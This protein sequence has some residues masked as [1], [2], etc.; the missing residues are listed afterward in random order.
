MACSL[1]RRSLP[2]IGRRGEFVIT[3]PPRRSWPRRL[4]NR[5]EVDRAVFYALVLRVWQLAGG[6]ISGV[7]I[8]KFFTIETQGYYYLFATLMALQSFFE[9]GFNVVV[10]NVSSHE[11]THLRLNEQGAIEGDARALSRLV[12]LGRLIFRWYAVACLLFIVAVGLGGGAFVAL[13]PKDAN[14]LPEAA[15]AVV[16]WQSPWA[17]LVVLTGLLLWSLPFNALLEGC[18]QIATVNRFRVIQAVSANLAVWTC[19]VSGGE[20]W[21]VVAAA[22]ARLLCDLALLLIRYRRFFVP[23]LKPPAGEQMHWRTDVWPMQW[24]LA[25]AGIFSYF[26]YFLFVPVMF[27]YHG[28]AT[29]ARMGLTWVLITAVQAAALAWVQ[30]RVPLFGILIARQE[31]TELDRVFRRVTMISLAVIVAGGAA[32]MWLIFLLN[33]YLPRYADRLLPPLPTAIFV[34]AIILYQLPHSQVFY[35]RAHKREPFLAVNILSSVAIGLS[36]WILGGIWGPTGAAT[37][38]LAVVG[39]LILPTHTLI[40]QHCRHRWHQHD[41][42]PTEPLRLTLVI[43]SLAGG[44]AERVTAMMANEW[45]RRGRDVT[46][47]TLD[48]A[49][50]DA[51]PLDE[52]VE[53]LGLDLM[54]ESRNLWAALRNNARRIIV[55]RRAIRASHPDRVVS[56][57]DKANV[58]TLAACIGLGVDVVIT[59]RTDPRRHEIGRVWGALRRL[60]Y[61]QCAALVVQTEAVRRHFEPIMRGRPVV[62]IPNAVHAPPKREGQAAD[63]PATG[64]RLVGMGRLD[65]HKG[66]DLLLEAFARIADRHPEWRLTILGE[67]PDRNRLEE[68]IAAKQFAGRVELRGWVADPNAVLRRSDL[69]VLP[70]RYEGFP[71][72]LLE[73]M[74]CGL[75][76]ISF[77]CDSGPR[78][79]IR[80]GVDGL[81][82]PT[83][84]V[85]ALIDALERL[86]SDEILRDRFAA[87]AADVVDRFSVE[88][89][90]ERWEGVLKHHE[91]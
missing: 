81:L 26:A 48:A 20:L 9:L 39:L 40:W 79:I 4:L 28:E 51:Y 22:A 19:I 76:A 8:V 31:Y 2:G 12:S 34:A 88:L 6:T 64:R 75:P 61:P 73:A 29:A 65:P 80:D 46:L 77:D 21:A 47:I 10:I 89:Y 17:A 41:Q 90:F 5:M 58:L 37:G 53:R 38:Y 18:G 84:D 55:L 68:I 72:A 35:V 14:D 69:F 23:F 50:H 11:W 66:F 44:G 74:A 63:T 57:T 54:R 42:P 85:D 15:T 60:L 86:M 33:V 45:S 52:R 56:F 3:E 1:H 91:R 27:R 62:V 16:D 59:E 67:G 70:S 30:T 7:L 83:G 49:E 82:V 43:H 32:I 13:G 78:E 25:L 36:V 24:R 87:R 71:N